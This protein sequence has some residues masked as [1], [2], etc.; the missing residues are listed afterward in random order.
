M[1]LELLTAEKNQEHRVLDN[2]RN[3]TADKFKI[4]NVQILTETTLQREDVYEKGIGIYS[5]APSKGYYVGQED[6]IKRDGGIMHFEDAGQLPQ[7][8]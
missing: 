3:H 7:I 8:A 4:Q 2:V 6:T 5:N 1:V